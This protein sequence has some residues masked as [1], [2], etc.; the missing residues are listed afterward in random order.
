MNQMMQVLPATYTD[1]M[2]MYCVEGWEVWGIWKGV[3]IKD[4]LDKADVQDDGEFVLFT[5][6]DGYQTAL[7]ISYLEKY[8]AMMAFHLD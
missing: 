6:R 7:P 4:L 2:I 3:L 8:D 1:T 5:S